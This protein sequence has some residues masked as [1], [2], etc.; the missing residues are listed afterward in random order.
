MLPTWRRGD[1]P[2]IDFP[3][4]TYPELLLSTLQRA[5][6]ASV[7]LYAAK[8]SPI[9]RL[10]RNFSCLPMKSSLCVSQK[11]TSSHALHQSTGNPD[12]VAMNSA[13]RSSMS[14]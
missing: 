12:T 9:A 6:S 4:V 7:N 3:G 13:Q 2:Y 11:S 8:Y 10:C 5:Y 1:H 14:H